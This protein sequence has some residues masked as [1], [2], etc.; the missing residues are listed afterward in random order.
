MGVQ[1]CQNRVQNL[2][3]CGPNFVV[4]SVSILRRKFGDLGSK[5]DVKL[6]QFW[7]KIVVRRDNADFCR[8]CLIHRPCRCSRRFGPSENSRKSSNL[9]PRDDNLSKLK[10]AMVRT[11]FFDDFRL[12]IGSR[13]SFENRLFKSL[14]KHWFTEAMETPGPRTAAA[15]LSPFGLS[16]GLCV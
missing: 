7:V 11:S 14:E 10:K 15:G 9:R 13:K 4:F 2:K 5:M 1:G 16:D 3:K 8:K 12:K 6:V